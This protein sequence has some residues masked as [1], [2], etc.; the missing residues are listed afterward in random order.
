MMFIRKS[1]NYLWN[2]S[3]AA[4][5][6]LQKQLKCMTTGCL[7]RKQ[8]LWLFIKFGQTFSCMILYCSETGWKD[9]LPRVLYHIWSFWGFYQKSKQIQTYF[10]HNNKSLQK[11]LEKILIKNCM[12]RWPFSVVVQL[13]ILSDEE[14]R[15]K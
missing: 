1:E 10:R 6:K 8:K 7:L 3:K 12:R 14:D 2:I 9:K 15:L 11:I 4:F 13:R 5:M